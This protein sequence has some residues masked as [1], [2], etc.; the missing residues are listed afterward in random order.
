MNS[1]TAFDPANLPSVIVVDPRFDA[2]GP[3]AVAAREGRINLHFRASGAEAMRLA[4]RLRV[5]AWLVAEE[6]DDMA[7]HDFVE[8][9]GTLA[10]DART[11]KVAMVSAGKDQPTARTAIAATSAREAGAHAFLSQPIDLADLASLL[12]APAQERA[13]TLSATA[14]T[15]GFLTVKVGIGAAMIAVAVLMMA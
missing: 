4:R 6:L 2:Y 9:L 3:L 10:D 5:D 13:A 11:G 12:A 15:P 7:G 14:A 1:S 8:L